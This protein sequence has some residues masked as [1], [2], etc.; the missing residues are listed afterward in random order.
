VSPTSRE[1]EVEAERRG[2]GA[3]SLK[4]FRI[5]VGAFIWP[6]TSRWL[7]A[8]WP[9]PRH[10]IVERP[11]GLVVAILKRRYT[12]DQARAL[13]RRLLA[14]LGA[15]DLGGLRK[16]CRHYERDDEFFY[17][18]FGTM[19]DQDALAMRRQNQAQLALYHRYRAG[20]ISKDEWERSRRILEVTMAAHH[21]PARA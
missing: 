6:G 10:P 9:E 2:V 5:H 14:V 16:L 7:I 8:A 21:T 4:R 20:E 12:E 3:V 1:P 11:D 19:S 13:F 18:A 15:G 17:I